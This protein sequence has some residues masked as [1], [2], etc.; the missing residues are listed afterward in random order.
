MR[1]YLGVLGALIWAIATTWIGITG[2]IALVDGD[3]GK[4][5]IAGAVMLALFLMSLA[6]LITAVVS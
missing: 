4:D 1:T 6:G 5:A 3:G 2:V